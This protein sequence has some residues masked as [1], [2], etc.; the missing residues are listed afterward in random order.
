MYNY[1]MRG[2]SESYYSAAKYQLRV[3]G[4]F[5]TAVAYAAEM[6]PTVARTPAG[7]Y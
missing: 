3:C 7:N 4:M 6:R 5:P 2:E 1:L